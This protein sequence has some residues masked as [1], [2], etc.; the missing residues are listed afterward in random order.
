M[1]WINRKLKLSADRTTLSVADEVVEVN[2]PFREIITFPVSFAAAGVGTFNLYFPY[3]VKITKIR[4]IVTTALAGTDAGSITCGN[5]TGASTT[6]VLSIPAS[7]AVAYAPTAV[8]PTTN[9]TVAADS[10]Y[11]ITTAKT[12]PNGEALVTLEY[13]RTY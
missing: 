6:G 2:F 10:Y 1:S 9:N 8:V 12:T 7:S 4:A 3:A 13:I 5:S 11:Y